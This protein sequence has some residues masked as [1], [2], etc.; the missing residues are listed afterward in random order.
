[1]VEHVIAGRLDL[2]ITV[3]P[4]PDGPLAHLHLMRDPCVLLVPAGSPL[5]RRRRAELDDL[6]GLP[7]V[8]YRTCMHQIWL[9]QTL[10]GMGHTL[11]IVR[12]ADENAALQGM[13]ADGTGAAVVPLLAVNLHDPGVAAVPFGPAMPPRQV[14]VVWH[15]DRELGPAARRVVDV[16]AEVCAEI[17]LSLALPEGDA[18]ARSRAG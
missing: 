13:V 10:A 4:L 6:D 17:E 8:A 12:R 3:W 5:A 14:V 7:M 15:R 16:A 9:E 18:G 2:A 11:D 1:M